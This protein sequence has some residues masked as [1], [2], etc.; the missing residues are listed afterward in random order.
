MCVNG[1]L[2]TV[3]TTPEVGGGGEEKRRMVE[4]VN[5]SIIYLIYCKN[6]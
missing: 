1:K 2:T 4:G 5:S 6:F 3:E